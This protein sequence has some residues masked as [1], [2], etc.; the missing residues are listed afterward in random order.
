MLCCTRARAEDLVQ[1]YGN[2]G[3]V[4]FYQSEMPYDVNEAEWGAKGYVG[5][6]VEE[7]VTSHSA[8]GVGVYHYFRDYKVT[9]Q[10]GIVCPSALEGGFDSPFV[11]FLNGQGTVD[12]VINNL[13]ALTSP[14]SALKT[15][16]VCS[17]QQRVH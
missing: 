16:Y 10:S 6:R 13:G 11:R 8:K 1:W 14:T 17:T 2:N 3:S 9:V 5:Y 4:F 12:H 15:A 7:S